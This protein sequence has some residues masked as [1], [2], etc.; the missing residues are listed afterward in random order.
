MTL[1]WDIFSQTTIQLSVLH[2]MSNIV[3]RWSSNI[4]RRP[5]FFEKNPLIVYTFTKWCKINWRLFSNFV[6]LSEYLN[7]SCS[8]NFCAKQSH[9]FPH[10][11][12]Q[13]SAYYTECRCNYWLS[14]AKTS[15]LKHT[16]MTYEAT[17]YSSKP[18]L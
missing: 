2:L 11:T 17:N 10:N 7:F 6:A 5:K 13:T 14:F 15:S 16:C 8:A 12:L 4:L 18:C 3:H 1:Y 9:L